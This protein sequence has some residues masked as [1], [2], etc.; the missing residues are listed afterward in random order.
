MSSGNLAS[1]REYPELTRAVRDLVLAGERFRARAGR[2]RGLGP[3]SVTVMTTLLLDGARG[4]SEL[5]ALLDITT[6]S[7]TE[8]IDRLE[9][10]GS[11]RRRPHPRDR[12]RVL[13]ELTEAGTQEIEA[14][15]E[16]FSARVESTGG[17]MDAATREAVLD[18]VR[19]VHRSLREDDRDPGTDAAS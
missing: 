2:R 4:P 7:A 1:M 16:A 12:R 14:V 18:V 13:V 10:L 15:F 6:A 11:V 9:R 17:A 5:A 3:T 19:A 8:L